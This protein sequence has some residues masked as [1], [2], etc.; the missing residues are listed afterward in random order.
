MKYIM[1]LFIYYVI[2]IDI[3]NIYFYLSFFWLIKR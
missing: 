1:F 3:F 2:I